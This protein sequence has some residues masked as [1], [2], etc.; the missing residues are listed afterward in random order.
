MRLAFFGSDDF[1][2][3]FFK[4][5][6]LKPFTK[7][8]V[9]SSHP[10]GSLMSYTK[11][12]YETKIISSFQSLEDGFDLAISASFGLFI[13]K[14]I[15]S[16][17]P[18]FLNVHPSLLPR[19]RGSSPI[20]RSIM[21]DVSKIGITIIDMEGGTFDSGRIWYQQSINQDPLNTDFK[22][23]EAFLAK[24]S[25]FA[26]NSMISSSFKDIVPRNQVGIIS[27]APKI[28][29]TDFEVLFQT[30][31]RRQIILKYNALSHQ[32][33]LFT[34]F[35]P[36]GR[37]IQLVNISTSQLLLC[38]GSPG[39]VFLDKRLRLIWI[40]CKDKEWLGVS[41]FR[42]EGKSSLFDWGNCK[43]ALGL[44]SFNKYF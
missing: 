16:S 32:R 35:V 11:G 27:M 10:A 33:S 15:V 18:I 23:M 8:V 28:Q 43:I 38:K 34:T 22:K 17:V 1:S 9:H 29:P 19:Y 13:P 44:E 14:R 42:I 4:N 7:I 5:L 25:S 36:D 39:D 20:Q 21:E 26:M 30:M 37:R 40:M 24:E 2:L 6:V 12:K 31:T 3:T 41:S